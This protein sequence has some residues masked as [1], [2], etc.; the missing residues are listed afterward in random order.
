MVIWCLRLDFVCLIMSIRLLQAV[1]FERSPCHGLVPSCSSCR[2]AIFNS[3]IIFRFFWFLWTR[4]MSLNSLFM[5]LQ[6]EVHSDRQLS[7]YYQRWFP[8]IKCILQGTQ[9]A[10]SQAWRRGEHW[11]MRE[12]SAGGKI[13]PPAES[14]GISDVCVCVC[15]CVWGG[16]C[17]F[18]SCPVCPPGRAASARWRRLDILH[19]AHWLNTSKKTAVRNLYEKTSVKVVMKFFDGSVDRV[20]HNLSWNMSTPGRSAGKFG[21]DIRD[22]LTFPPDAPPAVQSFHI[23]KYLNICVCW[24]KPSCRHSIIHFDCFHFHFGTIL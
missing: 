11:G 12:K 10:G 13:D 1:T 18:P 3:N 8:K 16:D 19:K 2:L 23:W 14:Q 21:A 17:P 7:R 9:K 4:N 22:P 5:S 24:C 15:V 6:E 20:L